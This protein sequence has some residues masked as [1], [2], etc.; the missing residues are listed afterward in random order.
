MPDTETESEDP[1]APTSMALTSAAGPRPTRR[2]LAVLAWA[3]WTLTVLGFVMFARFDLLLRRVGRPDLSLLTSSDTAPYLLGMMN[4]A[5]VGLVLAIR[6]PRHP[7]GWL[8]LA[9]GLSIGASAAATSYARYGLLARPGALP[10][11]GYAAVWFEVGVFVWATWLGF[12]LLLTPTGSLP[13]PRWRWWARTVVAAAV[14]GVASSALLPLEPPFQSAPNPLAV[15]A[16]AGPL[17]AVNGLTSLVTGLSVLVAAGSLVVRFRRASGVERQQLRWLAVAAALTAM[18]VLVLVALIPTGNELLLGWLSA[19]CIALLPLATGAAILRYRLYDL[20]RII[21]RTLAY[22]LLTVLLGLG[23]AGVVLA[24]GQ[25]FGQDSSMA[26]AGATLVV[27]VAFQPARRRVQQAVDRRFNRRRY[28]AAQTIQ[29]FSARLREEVDLDTL[30]AELLAVVEQTMQPAQA[31]LWLRP[32][33][34]GVSPERDSVR[35]RL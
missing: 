23:Y 4:A 9:L 3:L 20:D 26:V 31:W 8:L 25:L 15:P 19:V 17:Q 22:G 24:L 2:H 10:G 29:A 14:L 16:L 11:A 33:P 32:Q 30:S 27:A 13:S 7:V 12:I 21:S 5:T 1:H 35:L 34:T 18:V 28:D 6:R